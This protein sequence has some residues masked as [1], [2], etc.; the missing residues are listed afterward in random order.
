M[1]DISLDDAFFPVSSVRADGT[2]LIRSARGRDKAALVSFDVDI[3]VQAVVLENPDVDINWPTNLTYSFEPD[4]IRMGPNTKDRIALTPRGQVFLDII[5]QFPQPVDL[6]MTVP[7]SSGRYV[8][9]ALSVQGKSII[10]LLI[11]FEEK[12][13]VTLAEHPLRAYGEHLLQER[14]VPFTARE[15]L[16]I[17]AVMRVPEGVEGHVPFVV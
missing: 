3:G 1:I 11:V 16:E 6:Q 5:G 17:P 10:Y 14:A 15:G 4:L 2:V 13:Y 12:S 8:T 7:S 9:Q